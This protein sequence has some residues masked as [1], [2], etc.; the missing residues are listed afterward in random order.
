MKKK[1]FNTYINK[2]LKE[3]SISRE[4]LFTKTKE[5]YIVD[6]RQMLYWACI[7]DGGFNKVTVVR[8]MKENGYDIGH[9]TIIHG[10]NKMNDTEDKYYIKLK[11]KLCIN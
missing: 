5:Q 1:K 7:I 3:F 8:M 11:E 4:R 9:S 6:A 2:I 10:I